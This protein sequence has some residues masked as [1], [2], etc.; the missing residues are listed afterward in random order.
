MIHKILSRQV[1]LCGRAPYCYVSVLFTAICLFTSFAATAQV[2]TASI[3]GTVRDA[4]GAAIAGVAVTS[5]NEATGVSLV[6]ATNSEGIYTFPILN[7][8]V[9][10]VTAEYA[11][12]KKAAHKGIGLQV[13]QTVRVDLSLEVGQVTEQVVI[14]S[15]TPLVENETSSLGRVVSERDVVDLPLNQRNF[16][17]LAV[18]LP[19]S[20]F[21]AAGTIG[22]GGRPDDPRPRSSIFV[23]G[24]RDSSNSYLV[25]G[26][27]NYDRIHTTIAVKPSIDAIKEFKVQTSLYSAE[28]GRNAGGVINV[29]VKSGSN[30][31]RGTAYEFHRNA[32][33]DAKNFF[34]LP[35][36]PKPHFLFN[37]FGG[38]IGGPLRRDQTFFFFSYEGLRLRRGRTFVSTVPTEAMRRGDFSGVGPIFDPLTTRQNPGGTGFI[39]DQFRDNLIPAN[40]IDPAASKLI[41]LYPLPNAPGMVSN[42]VSNPVGE[43]NTDQVDA[44][45]DHSFGTK[46]NLFVRYSFGDTDT[47][48]PAPLPGK[49]Q[50]GAPFN[51]SGPNK[52]RTQ[53]VAIG[54][55]YTFGNS[56]VNELRVDYTRI[57]S[58]VLPFFYGENL[59]EE[60]GIPGANLETGSSGLSAI[61]LTGFT[62]LG[63]SLFLPILKFI[64]NY[65]VTD[66]LNYVRG[67]HV[68][69]F[70]AHFLRPQT[71]HFQSIAPAGRFAFSPVFTNNPAAPAGTGNA[72]ATFLL[73]YPNLT[74][75]SAQQSPNYLRY[76]EHATYVQDD[77][78]IHPRLTLNLGLRYELITPA[79]SAN[80]HLTNFDLQTGKVLIAG[81]NTT[82]TGGVKTDKNNFAP[83]FGFAFTPTPRTVL[84]GGYGVFYDTV[85]MFA[86]LRPFPFLI[87]YTRTTGSFF[88]ENRLSEGFPPT[89]FDIA[90]NAANPFGTVDA[91]PFDNPLGYVQQFNLNIQRSLT[92]NLVVSAAY[93]GTMGRKLRW[94]YDENVPDPGPGAVQQRRP[95]FTRAPEVVGVTVNHAEASSTYH[96]LQISVAKRL[97]S[98]LAFQGSYTWSHWI[99]NAISEAGY[100]AQGPNPQNIRN[101]R[102]ERGNDPADLRHR[103]VFSYI[104]ELPFGE[105]KRWGNRNTAVTKIL[106]GWQINGITTL[107]SGLPFTPVLASPTTNTGTGSRPDRIGEGSLP[108]SQR[109][110]ERFFDVTAFTTPA[111]FTYGNA[112]RNIL[113]GPGYVN[114]DFS[115]FKNVRLGET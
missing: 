107:Q 67:R 45:V 55:T 43:Q 105:G 2:N 3:R 16:V 22:G 66:N 101:R 41:Q 111:Q 40:R 73:G 21:G 81:E 98:G 25:D 17:Q 9:Y 74:Q 34:T 106:G 28:F 89:D 97:S 23:N 30:S 68:L 99:D 7:V 52:L 87:T 61:T 46:A 50:G 8:G 14:E 37:Q 6:T 26:I 5:T 48:T 20:N 47:I 100:G 77:W 24:T 29:S 112:G 114:F 80:D 4:N 59:S 32:A 110:L 35:T 39:R 82:R 108:R 44:R 84:R 65:Q 42:F 15:G 85:P 54:S 51:F 86:Q 71:N 58:N 56:L 18:L 72:L 31:F 95:F 103:L 53:G 104:Y 11:G 96:S 93:V 63:N 109:T 10:T 38:T 79:V 76:V 94:V 62:S 78:K 69:K 33:L 92:S 64:N 90:K 27:D 91:V 113:Y 57:N 60:A 13:N 19:G 1:G 36:Q 49:A 115:L 75:R 102:A 88:V 83:R 70:G 12:F